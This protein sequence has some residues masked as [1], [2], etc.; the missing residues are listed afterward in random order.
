MQRIMLILAVL[1]VGLTTG[2]IRGCGGDPTDNPIRKGFY[3]LTGIDDPRSAKG[4]EETQDTYEFIEACQKVGGKMV[5][6]EDGT[7]ACE[8]E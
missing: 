2:G 3:R 6:K 7:F 8:T 4:Q 5:P 1:S